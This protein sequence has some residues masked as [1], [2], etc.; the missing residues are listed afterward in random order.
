MSQQKNFF[1]GLSFDIIIVSVQTLRFPRILLLKILK[2]K[3]NITLMN[4]LKIL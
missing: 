3:I 4:S 1:I 2:S